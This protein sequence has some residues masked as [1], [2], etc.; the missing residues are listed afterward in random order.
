MAPIIAIGSTALVAGT[1]ASAG[2]TAKKLAAPTITIREVAPGAFRF[3]LNGTVVS[4]KG[5]SGVFKA[6]IGINRVSEFWAPALYQN[7]SSISVVPPAA[8]LSAS[9]KDESVTVRLAAGK[10]AI[11]TFTNFKLVVQQPVTAPS[12]PE[13]ATPPVANPAPANPAPGNPAPGNPTAGGSDPTGTGYI[14][15]CKTAGDDMVEGTFSFAVTAGTSTTPIQTATLTPV[16]GDGEICTGALP[17]PAGTVTV[18]EGSEA[19]AY[20]VEDVWASPTGALA[21]P[22]VTGALSANFTVT[23]GL[24]TTAH[25]VNDTSLNSIK[26]CK[27]L[28]SDTG[29]LAGKQFAFGVSWTFTP[30]TP[31]LPTKT[32]TGGETDYVVAVTA[33]TGPVCSIS[34][35]IPATSVVDVTED[36]AVVAGATLSPSATAPYVSV[37]NVAIVPNTFNDGSTATEAILTVPPVG[38]GY[39]DAYFTNDP[40]GSIEVCKYFVDPWSPYNNGINSATFIV[41]AGSF[42]S[43][44][45]TVLGGECSPEMVVPAGTAT[46]QEVSVSSV[47]KGVDESADYYLENITATATVSGLS[48]GPQNELTSVGTANPA[49]VNVLYGGV[50]STTEVTFTNGVDPTHFKICKQTTSSQL[51]G[52]TF[53]F[54]WNFAGTTPAVDDVSLPPEEHIVTLTITAVEPGNVCSD[55]LT[56]IPVVNPS[57]SFNKITVTE[58]AQTENVIATDVTLSGAGNVLNSSIPSGPDAPAWLCFNPGY[59]INIVTFTNEYYP[60]PVNS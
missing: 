39:A 35:L 2:A 54:E 47:I 11:V 19:P 59:G 16:Y 24:E 55:V 49:S 12:N 43:A 7:L 9:L 3:A 28:A 44:P 56:D 45:I 57:G 25:F 37:S 60:S 58:E 34:G 18:T 30:P 26:V 23:A 22:W 5:S 1:A 41:T 50:A 21:S 33:E 17:V 20:Y 4:L 32:F 46:V 15:I 6:K 51:V 29:S 13:P 31:N 38:D 10:S 48:G 53:T 8:R 36:G 52:A 14:E 40:M 42:T 27:V